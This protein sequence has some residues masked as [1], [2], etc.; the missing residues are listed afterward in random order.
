LL[1][2][3]TDVLFYGSLGILIFFVIFVMTILELELERKRRWKRRKKEEEWVP[4]KDKDVF[5][6]NI[7]AAK[8]NK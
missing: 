2:A 6:R 1:Q 5:Y 8:K 3:I 4:V 7:L